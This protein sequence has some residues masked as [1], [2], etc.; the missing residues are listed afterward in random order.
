MFKSAAIIMLFGMGFVFLFLCIQV[1]IT[2]L[3]AKLAG[4]FAY[5]LPEPVK[6]TKKPAAPKSDDA[7]TVAVIAAALK[8]AGR[9]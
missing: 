1:V 4:R 5:L 6:T 3:F 2:N 7:L 9:L 8:S